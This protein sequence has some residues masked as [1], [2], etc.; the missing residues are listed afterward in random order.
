MKKI[1]SILIFLFVASAT[2]AQSQEIA[3]KTSARCGT[4]KKAI[5]K[6]LSHEKGIRSAELNLEDQVI[7]VSYNPDKTSPEKIRQAISMVGYDADDV[8][9]D[10]NAYNRLADCCKKD[11]EVHE[12]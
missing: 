9:A 11:A 6:A 8:P 10:E 5:H 3:I 12:D 4:C 1:I 7:L 2:Y